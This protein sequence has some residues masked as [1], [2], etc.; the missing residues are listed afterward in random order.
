MKSSCSTEGRRPTSVVRRHEKLSL[1]HLAWVAVL[2]PVAATVAACVSS[3][4]VPIGTDCEDGFCADASAPPPTFTPPPAADGGEAGA[5]V[6]VPPPLLECIGTDCPYPYADC[7]KSPS[8]FRCQTN[9]MNDPANCGACGVSCL[10]FG[11]I[12]MGASCI[13]GKCVFECQIK[14]DANGENMDF[15]DC[16]GLLDDGCEANTSGDPEN[17]GACG[18][19]CPSGVRCIKGRCGCPPGLTDCN[20]RCVDTRFD[21]YNCSTCGNM[22]TK[23]TP[24][25]SPMP[26][27]T[28]YGCAMSECG[29]LKCKSGFKDCNGDLNN[30]CASDGC[31]TEIAKDPKNCGGCGIECAPDQ[32]CRNDGYGPQ[33]LDKCSKSGLTQCNSGCKDLLS[34]QG[35]CGACNNACP[36]PRANQVKGCK[37]GVCVLDCV[38]GFADCNGDPADGCEVDLT[39]HPAHCGACG[40]ECDFGAGQP[41]I[42]GRCRMVECD[43]G[44]ETTK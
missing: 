17:C 20:G 18:N 42:E 15:R 24:A 1:A 8:S 34:D 40:N 19:V 4:E 38:P 33:C 39:R 6:D 9:L 29:K 13:D 25:C 36:N 11:G 35:N 14:P 27:Q 43:G 44:V 31:E 41:C 28:N 32:E 30:G 16:N 21:D 5:S 22:C 23:P 12:N 7:S 3:P 10:G 26:F 37:K 2:L